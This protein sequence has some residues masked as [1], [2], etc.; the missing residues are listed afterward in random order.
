MMFHR[1]GSIDKNQKGFTLVEL[2]IALAITAV[3]AGSVTTAVFQVF[4]GN[5]R[6]SNHMTAVRQVQE[7]GYWVSH[8]TQMAQSV[9]ATMTSPAILQLTWTDWESKGNHKVVYSL[10]PPGSGLGRLLQRSYSINGTAQNSSTIARYIDSSP[11]QTSCIT[12][13]NS[14]GKLVFTV[15]A[16]VGPSGSQ[17]GSETRV[18]EVVPRPSP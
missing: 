18:Y 12:S 9:N 13:D 7:A 8:D 6:T 10:D 15:T 2:L 4:T 17:Q 16:T 3:I 5:A 14:T 11:T 1:L